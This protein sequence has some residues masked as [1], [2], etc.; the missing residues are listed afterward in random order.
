MIL[1]L[2]PP[3]VSDEIAAL[4]EQQARATLR[5]LTEDAP[6]EQL[7]T[8][9][10]LLKDFVGTLPARRAVY[11]RSIGD[12]AARMLIAEQFPEL[13]YTVEGSRGETGNGTIVHTWTCA[14]GA[15]AHYSQGPEG[16]TV[17]ESGGVLRRH[18]WDDLVGLYTSFEMTRSAGAE[19]PDEV[20]ETEAA[21]SA[22]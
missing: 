1:T 7:D 3:A 15:F 10:A 6:A 9:I 2:D 8:L 4:E 18:L 20:V 13:T 19:D 5:N 14:T 22:L 21:L 11:L 17:T 12:P 16:C